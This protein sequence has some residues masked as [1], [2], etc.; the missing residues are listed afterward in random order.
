MQRQRLTGGSLKAGGYDSRERI[1]EL[2][3]TDGRIRRYKGVPAEV[4]QRM[5]AAPSAGTF[6]DDRIAEEYPW[7]EAGHAGVSPDARARLDALFGP[8]P[9]S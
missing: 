3:F 5:R 9:E 4:W 7:E 8:P 2:E 6:H 1:L